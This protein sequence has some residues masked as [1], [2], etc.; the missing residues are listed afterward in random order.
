MKVIRKISELIENRK[1]TVEC[2]KERE[3][4]LK[5]INK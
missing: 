1:Y 5:E 4:K 3:V 2:Y